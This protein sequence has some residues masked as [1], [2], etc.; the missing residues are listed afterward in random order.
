M[1][2]SK[3]LVLGGDGFI[4]WPLSLYL[5][6]RNYRVAIADNL[7]R[8]KIGEELQADSLTP[9]APIAERL[10]AWQEVADREID[11]HN[12]D[13]AADYESL[14]D[15]IAT[16]RPDAVIHLAEQK[17]APY[18]MK[19]PKTKRYTIGNNINATHNVL[20]ALTE[21]SPESHLVHIGSMGV[22]GYSG[23][24]LE[25]PEGYIRA[26]MTDSGGTSLE[27][28]ILFPPDP[29]SVYHA[30]K[31]MDQILFQYYAANDSLRI[32]DLHQGVVWGTA[33]EE[34]ELDERLINRF[35]YDG[36]YGTVL[37]R[38]LSQGAI[39]YP[40]T[41]YG[42]GGQTRAFIHIKDSMRCLELALNHPPALGDRVKIFNQMT[43][44][45]TIKELADLISRMMNIE[46]DCLPN[47]RNEAKNNSLRVENK[48]M[49]KL[50]LEPTLLNE[51]L[52]REIAVVADKYRDRIREERI[53]CRS[54]WNREIESSLR[55]SIQQR[56]FTGR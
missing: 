15:L 17:A 24:K 23:I 31:C 35:D 2:E 25:L 20:C 14:R 3:V 13:V 51:G 11:F 5:S 21:V 41:V 30:S 56:D 53:P 39:G 28:D 26:R 47:P 48:L 29:G 8:R 4:G 12:I 18:S 42:T 22:Y 44:V 1:K 33:T 54:A 32:T 46:V 38:F 19:T 43:E 45:H 16:F 27:R 49:R 34:T 52:L 9:I 55:E 37:N 10:N 50:G 6:R 36:D 40:L 7:S